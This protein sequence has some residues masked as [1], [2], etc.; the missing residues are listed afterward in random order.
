[1]NFRYIGQEQLALMP[2]RPGAQVAST[3]PALQELSSCQMGPEGPADTAPGIRE[4][5]PL[6]RS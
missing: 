2:A 1:M 6:E 5:P 3:A 4:G